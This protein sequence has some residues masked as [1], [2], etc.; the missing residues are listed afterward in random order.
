[1]KW[2]KAT[3]I[4]D[5]ILP[6][7]TVLVKYTTSYIPEFLLRF[8]VEY[9]EKS[10]IPILI[11]DNFDTLHSILIRAKMMNLSLNLN[12]VYVIKTGGKLDVGNVVAKVQFHPDPR[13][14]LKNYEEA[15]QKALQEIPT[16]LINLVVGVENLFL[17][18]RTPLDAYRLILA[19]QRFMG[20]RNRKA[21][22]IVNETVMESLPIRILPEFERISTTVIRL[23]PYHTGAT[24]KVTKSINPNLIGREEKIDIEGWI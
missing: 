7:E 14:Y 22:Y 1:M 24:L 4:A 13:V 20:N 18:I 12:K 10:G 2:E 6:G 21:F 3:E 23:T 8:F 15:I 19:M 16:P 11:D 9:S 5:S 17:I